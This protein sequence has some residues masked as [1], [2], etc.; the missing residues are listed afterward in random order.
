MMRMFKP[1]SFIV[2]F[3][4]LLSSCSKDNGIDTQTDPSDEVLVITQSNSNF[5]AYGVQPGKTLPVMSVLWS[6]N[7]PVF[8]KS[9]KQL[10]AFG[11]LDSFSGAN[12][13]DTTIAFQK[14]RTESLF[15]INPETG[16][17]QS[18]VVLHASPNFYV[19]DGSMQENAY[20]R[21]QLQT[22]VS[23]IYDG[24]VYLIQ[25]LQKSQQVTRS[26]P[27]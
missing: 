17:R 21:D 18:G 15:T 19:T 5:Y 20:A 7:A 4:T 2:L 9:E 14:P 6:T 27:V 12:W 22:T 3:V 26:L 10:V 24:T 25:I 16:Q 23:Q 13:A 8:T 11:G 1:A